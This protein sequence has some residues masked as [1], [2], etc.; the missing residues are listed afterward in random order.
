MQRFFFWDPTASETT[1]LLDF[2]PKL[3]Y[4]SLY[5]IH[6]CFYTLVGWTTD[7]NIF[8]SRFQPFTGL[9]VFTGGR[10]RELRA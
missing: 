10:R 3:D 7:F 1:P 9:V 5:Y 8:T 4:A 2:R 6:F